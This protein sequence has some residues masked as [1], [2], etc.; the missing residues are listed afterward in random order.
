[1]DRYTLRVNTGHMKRGRLIAFEGIDGCGKSTQLEMLATALTA[2]GIDVVSTREPTDGPHGQRIRAMARSGERVEAPLELEW[3]VLDRRE[4][5]ASVIEPALAGGQVV[6]TDRYTLSSVCYQGARG[7]DAKAILADSE[8]QFP[9][10]DLVILV[11]IDPEKGLE[12]VNARGGVAEPVFEEIDF[13]RRV[14]EHFAALDCSY[15]VRVSGDGSPEHVHRRIV[16]LVGAR[17][18]LEASG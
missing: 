16:E 9:I 11:E 10:P 4:H 15:L 1:M 12:R 14:A 3:F 18:D 5:V 6:L 8:A 17:L 7:L 2:R 13:Q